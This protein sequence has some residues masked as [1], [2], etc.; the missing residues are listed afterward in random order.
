[1]SG[2]GRVVRLSIKHRMT[3]VGT[4]VTALGVGLLWGG[5]IGALYPFLDIAFHGHSL[6]DRVGETLKQNSDECEQLAQR[7]QKLESLQNEGTHAASENIDAQLRTAQRDLWW[8]HQGVRGLEYAKTFLDRYVPRDP[9]Q[10]LVLLV[11][12]LFC[13]H[14]RQESHPRDQHGVRGPALAT[15]NL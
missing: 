5:D 2:F 10:T 4:I 6:Q 14:D 3:F 8:K 11:G 7:I 1:M 13:G 15:G 9:F 12:V